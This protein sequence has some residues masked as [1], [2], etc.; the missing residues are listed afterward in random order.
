MG[1]TTLELLSEYGWTALSPCTGS[2]TRTAALL[3]SII[4]TPLILTL[5]ESIPEGTLSAIGIRTNRR[6]DTGSFFPA[7][8]SSPSMFP[9]RP[10]TERRRMASMKEGKLLAPI[11]TWTETH[12]DF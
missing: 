12:M 3:T 5:M 11:L 7:A 2:Y 6:L 9:M 10:P 1:S 4:R 8:E